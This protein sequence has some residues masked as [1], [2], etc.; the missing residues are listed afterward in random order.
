MGIPFL[1]VSGYEADDIMATI[2][3]EAAA[4]GLNVFLCTADK[5][6]RQLISEHVK[7][8][9]LRKPEGGDLLD[10]AG[11]LADW[12]VNPDQVIDFQALVGDSVDNIPGV[13]GVGPKT[14]SKWLQQFNRLFQFRAFLKRCRQCSG[15]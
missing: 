11:V 3:V 15:Y 9:N 10:A 8:L 2:S 6:C 12:G 13:P 5:D 7:V 4:R 14:A 1:T